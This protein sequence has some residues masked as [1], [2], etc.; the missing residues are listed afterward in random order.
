M[1]SSLC[2]ALSG[3]YQCDMRLLFVY[4]TTYILL[5]DNNVKSYCTLE[6]NTDY[7]TGIVSANLYQQ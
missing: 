6:S 2:G 5:L 3:H 1:S 4:L 7:E